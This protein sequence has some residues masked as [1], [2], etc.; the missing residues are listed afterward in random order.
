MH[1]AP[2]FA[3]STYPF[4]IICI[5]VGFCLHHHLT[6]NA[7]GPLVALDFLVSCALTNLHASHVGHLIIGII[8]LSLS[9]VVIG[10]PSHPTI[11]Y[12]TLGHSK[13][14]VFGAGVTIHMGRMG[15]LLCLVSG[16]L[17]YSAI[18]PPT[19]GPPLFLLQSGAP[20]SMSLLTLGEWPL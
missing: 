3:K 7:Y 11:V 1:L 18:Q 20:L 8:I 6:Q 19:P 5:T 16:F 4:Y 14:D 15:Q 10:S 13:T 9:D 17:T 12:L 2:R